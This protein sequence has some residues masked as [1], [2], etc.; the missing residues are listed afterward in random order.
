MAY[1]LYTDS[2]QNAFFR[3]VSPCGLQTDILSDNGTTFIGAKSELEELA[4]L[5]RG[6]IQEKTASY[7]VK[8]HFNPPL[9]PHFS[10]VPELM[11][12]AAKKV[13][14]AILSCADVMDEELLNAVVRAEGLLNSRPFSYQSIHPQDPFPLTPNHFMGSWVVGLLQTPW[15]AQTSINDD[16]GGE[17]KNLSA[18]FGIDGLESGYLF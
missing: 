4:V 16:N 18:I 10:R 1:G 6:K 17:S 11:I 3:M 8:S 5:D 7:G 14:Y 13:I 15:I 12:K 9:A 2:F